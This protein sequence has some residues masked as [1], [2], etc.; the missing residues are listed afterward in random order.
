MSVVHAVLA[1]RVP[2]ISVAVD[3]HVVLVHVMT[4]A[5]IV[6]HR[7]QRVNTNGQVDWQANTTRYRKKKTKR[8]S[9]LSSVLM[10]CTPSG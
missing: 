5:T 8:R 7:A 3:T 9:T 1:V 6:A 10:P 4:A 2:D